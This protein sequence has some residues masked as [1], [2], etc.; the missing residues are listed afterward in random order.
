MYIT[1]MVVI[2]HKIPCN[3][4]NLILR[5]LK[6]MRECVCGERR[7]EDVVTLW[8]AILHDSACTSVNNHG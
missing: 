1:H 8:G 6:T 4:L 3:M 5:G 7:G 2:Y